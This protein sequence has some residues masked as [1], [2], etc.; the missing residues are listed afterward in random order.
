M[1]DRAMNSIGLTE[2]AEVEHTPP[3]QAG[4]RLTREEFER[5]Y[6]AM[7]HLKKAELIEG[8]VY[9]PSPTSHRNHGNPHFNLIGWLSDYA[10]GT[11][12][13][14]GGDS[15]SLRLDLDNEPQPD[16][17]LIVLPDHGGQVRI[18]E[19]GGFILG[20][21]EL[22]AEVAA[23]S[24]NYDLHD[25]LNA[26]RR[27]G[28]LEYVVW[29]VFDRAVDWFVLQKGRYERLELDPSG[30]YKSRVLPGLWLNPAALIDRDLRTVAQTAQEGISSAEH[31]DFV[32]RL[33]ATAGRAKP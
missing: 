30:I 4:D 16:A 20:A 24:A 9:V 1:M 31:A 3:L 13:V 18:D 21:P 10:E 7:P 27:N 5:R 29:R 28:V 6:N 8:V 15:G 17:Y 32:S 23:S 19:N 12:G 26:Y 11:P 2:P 25:K 22:V 14:E 33:Q